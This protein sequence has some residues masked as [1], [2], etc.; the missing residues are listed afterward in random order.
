MSVCLSVCLS[1]QKDIANRW[2]DWV[3]LDKIIG[4]GKVYTNFGGGYH[5]PPNRNHQK[6]DF[7]YVLLKKTFKVS[8]EASR[9]V[10]A[11]PIK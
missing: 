1:V 4:P 9:G 3:L 2:T 5:H 11:R 8:L 7:I 6:I 10:A